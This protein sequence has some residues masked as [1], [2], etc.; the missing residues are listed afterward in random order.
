MNIFDFVP[1]P[2]RAYAQPFIHLLARRTH[3]KRIWPMQQQ[4]TGVLYPRKA[5]LRTPVFSVPAF[6]FLLQMQGITVANE[7]PKQAMGRQ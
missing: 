6:N 3:P 5:K 1:K 2:G 7:L 4:F